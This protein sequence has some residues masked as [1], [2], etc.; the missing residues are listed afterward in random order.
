MVEVTVAIIG[1]LSL[2]ISSAIGIWAGKQAKSARENTQPNG[3][4]TVVKMAGELVDSVAQL[5]ETVEQ[6]T[7]SGETQLRL[8]KS[9][10]R[11][12]EKVENEHLATVAFRAA[13][14]AAA[15]AIEEELQKHAERISHLERPA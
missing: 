9:I 3:K 6:L 11:R 1:G 10:D 12:V 2:V 4:G 15:A 5:T 8:L 13:M 7:D 14:T